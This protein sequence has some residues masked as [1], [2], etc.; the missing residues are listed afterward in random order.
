MNLFVDL[1][2]ITVYDHQVV[3]KAMIYQARIQLLAKGVVVI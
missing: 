1:L 3:N 2:I